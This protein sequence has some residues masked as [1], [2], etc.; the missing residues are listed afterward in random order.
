MNPHHQTFVNEMILHN[1]AVRAYKA[2]YPNAQGE[3]ARTAA[4]RLMKKEEI[5]Q[6]IADAYKQL[7]LGI[8]EDKAAF[9][10]N[11]LKII[12]RKR[13]MLLELMFGTG[14]I[15]PRHRMMAMKLDN[16]LATQ[17]AYLLGYGS[18]KPQYGRQPGQPNQ[19]HHPE[20]PHQGRHLE[21]RE[22]SPEHLDEA[23][24]TKPVTRPEVGQANRNNNKAP[25]Q[26]LRGT[27]Q[28]QNNAGVP[29]VTTRLPRTYLPSQILPRQPEGFILAGN[30][31]EG[32][33]EPVTNSNITSPLERPGEVSFPI[34]PMAY[35]SP[36]HKE[37]MQ[38]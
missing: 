7:R 5:R 30:D 10:H 14:D 27:K 38:V 33:E 31:E 11:E 35:A 19:S 26:S 36:L 18:L 17:Q 24:T 21:R 20:Q 22:R 23:K 32:N 12:D 15:T 37:M 6:P 34:L 1:D 8:R 3:A 16:E 2:A 28:S 29:C 9:L 25:L 13:K 4:H